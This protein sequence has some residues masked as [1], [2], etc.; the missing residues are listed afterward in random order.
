MPHYYYPG[1]GLDWRLPLLIWEVAT[2]YLV[3]VE[4]IRIRLD[5]T[6]LE[7]SL[8]KMIDRAKSFSPVN[9]T[10]MCHLC[11]KEAFNTSFRPELAKVKKH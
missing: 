3:G 1:V 5:W 9:V 11:V 8:A 7:L 6:E 4:I 2:A 10:G